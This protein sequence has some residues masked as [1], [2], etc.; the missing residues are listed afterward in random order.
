MM[1]EVIDDFLD[2]QLASQSLEFWK[3]NEKNAS[4]I[5]KLT[6]N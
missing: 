5:I 1:K 6:I 3:N 4:S 2:C